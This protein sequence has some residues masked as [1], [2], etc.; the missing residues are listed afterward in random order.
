M[1]AYVTL[2][3]NDLVRATDFYDAVL[4][5]MGAKRVHANDRLQYYGVEAGQPMFGVGVP[6]DGSPATVGNGV[7]TAITVAEKDMVD[8]VHAKACELGGICEGQP[9]YRLPTF[10]GAYFRDLD[11]NKL[12]VCKVG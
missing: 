1:L 6:F 3:T 11:G 12:C 4:G 7:M 5:E 8:R 9:G 2:G 10:Y